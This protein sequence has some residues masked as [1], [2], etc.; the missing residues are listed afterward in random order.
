M[1]GRDLVALALAAERGGVTS[2]QLRLKHAA[3]RELAQ[4]VRDLVRALTR[5]GTGERPARRGHRR[6]RGGGSPR[7]GRHAGGAGR[8]IAPP[9]FL[10]GAS[11]GSEAEASRGQGGRLLGD[12]SLARHL[13]QAGRRRRT[14]RRR[15]RPAGRAGRREGRASPSAGSAGGCAGGAG[16]GGSGVAVVSG[17][18][19]RRTSRRRRG[20]T[21]RLR[22]RVVQWVSR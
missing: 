12:R 21:R 1:R 9:G 8:R 2:V 3:A 11:V 20:Y 17:I 14:G 6:W 4:L 5:A 10:M 13:D 16:G 7:P 15:L 22:K 18:L 19:G